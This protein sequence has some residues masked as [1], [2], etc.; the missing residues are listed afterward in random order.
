MLLKDYI[1][2]S[3]LSSRIFTAIYKVQQIEIDFY[4][5][6]VKDIVNQYTTKNATWSLSFL[7]KSLGIAVDGTKPYE[8]RRSVIKSKLR[9][10][11]TIT[12][13][14]IK[15][16]SESY[17][18]GEVDI[19]ENVKPYTFEIKFIGKK[20]IPPNIEDLK[21]AIESIKPAHLAVIYTFTYNTYNVIKNKTHNELSSLTN[22]EIRTHIF[23]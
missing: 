19:I 12:V 23:R 2:S 6:I 1:S 20:G 10:Q 4:Y 22:D 21:I 11:G 9:G 3:L 13:E 7:E 16:V 14:L 8:Y 15:N 5:N 17:S 18:N